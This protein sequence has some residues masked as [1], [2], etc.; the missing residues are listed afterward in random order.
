MI[1]YKG[2]LIIFT[3]FYNYQTVSPYARSLCQTAIVLMKMGIDFDYWEIEGGFH[4]EVAINEALTR[5]SE[6]D[7]TD[8]L[9][10]ESDESWNPVSVVD[11]LLHVDPIVAGTYRMKNGKLD[12]IGD[13]NRDNKGRLLGKTVEKGRF[14][15][16][17]FRVP[18]GFLRI[19]KEVVLKYIETYPDSYFWLNNKKV[20]PFFFNEIIDHTFT[21]MDLCLSDKLRELGY[22]I[23]V[24]PMF[25]IDHWGMAK[26]TGNFDKYLKELKDKEKQEKKLKKFWKR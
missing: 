25:E 24:D 3:P 21:G 9:M 20:Y 14:L 23:W 5:F 2:K 22:Q 6:S 7:A 15:L 12:Y 13:Y 10:I 4:V 8:F 16:E 26:F 19:K 1:E 11:S 18:A 17:A